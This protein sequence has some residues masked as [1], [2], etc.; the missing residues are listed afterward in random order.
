MSAT[1]RLNH[2]PTGE[3]TAEMTTLNKSVQ[4]ALA[5]L[6]SAASD[7]GGETA[8]GL[9]RRTGLPWATAVRFIRT[10]E[11]EGFLFRL[12]ESDRYVLG[13]EA[14]QLGRGAD[15][16]RL[17]AAIA[18]P[19]LERLAAGLQETVNLTVVRADGSLEVVEEI[20]SPRLLRTVGWDRPYPLHATSIGK[21]LL[22]TYDERVLD[23]F[24]AAPL[25]RYT[26]STIW[27]PGRLRAE[28]A[29]VR[30]TGFGE[31][32]DELEEGLTG[33][34]VGVRNPRGELLAMITVSGPT[35]RL[36]AAARSAARQPLRD[37]AARI[38]TLLVG[39]TVRPGRAAAPGTGSAHRRRRA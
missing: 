28:L 7:A 33:I 17:L 10:L 24:L 15:E 30:E 19:A 5:I 25:E 29:R 32:V 23:G 26:G 31:A 39:E 20:D 1:R 3:S 22:A 12:P 38:E 18:R 36:D 37:A 16:A 8:A 34:S 27:D 35:F 11:A 6:R 9:A 2:L 21:L 13:L 4:K 14:L